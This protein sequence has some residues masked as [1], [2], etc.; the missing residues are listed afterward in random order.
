M[1][2]GSKMDSI[3]LILFASLICTMTALT[4]MEVRRI[5]KKIEQRVA[6]PM[7]AKTAA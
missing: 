1:K 7:R 2:G 5:R 4:F 6:E 3:L